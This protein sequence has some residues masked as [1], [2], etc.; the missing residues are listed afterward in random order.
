MKNQASSMITGIYSTYIDDSHYHHMHLLND[1]ENGVSFVISSFGG[2]GDLTEK[3]NFALNQM[4]YNINHY[5]LYRINL[6]MQA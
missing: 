2:E 5:S 3:F 1:T 6:K 4:V